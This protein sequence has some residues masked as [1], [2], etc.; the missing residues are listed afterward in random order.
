MSWLHTDMR[1]CPYLTIFRK[2]N[3]S[4]E[5]KAGVKG[6]VQDIKMESVIVVKITLREKKAGPVVKEP[7]MVVSLG[8]TSLDRERM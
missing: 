2:C 7:L 4:E 8:A 6:A 5:T 1:F 3:L